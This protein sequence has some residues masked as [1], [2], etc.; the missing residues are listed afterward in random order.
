MNS[1]CIELNTKNFK[2]WNVRKNKSTNVQLN[3]LLDNDFIPTSLLPGKL[4]FSKR[5]SFPT[6]PTLLTNT[7]N[8][9]IYNITYPLNFR[10]NPKRMLIIFSS[11][12]SSDYLNSTNVEHRYIVNTYMD[13]RKMLEEELII[14]RIY[15]VNR[16][17]GSFYLNTSNFMNYEDSIIDL[18]QFY[19]SKF[20]INQNNL[21]MLGAFKGGTGALYY[22]HKMNIKNVSCDPVIDIEGYLSEND[23]M[24]LLSSLN[25]KSIKCDL[26][27]N[28][29][30]YVFCSQHISDTYKDIASLENI[31][32][33]ELSDFKDRSTLF[34]GSKKEVLGLVNYL[35]NEGDYRKI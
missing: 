16:L 33:I 20:D 9:V 6:Y 22:G 14:L 11:L 27:S 10:E 34:N 28:V 8:G 31:N 25:K 3:D 5:E 7:K 35:L 29:R 13:K 15:D 26:S 17:S 1:K 24:C 18:I 32:M 21:V 23:F 30:S 12:P 19:Q 2:F 4:L